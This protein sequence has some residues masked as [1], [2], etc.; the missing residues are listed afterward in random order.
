MMLFV[1]KMC[2]MG[3]PVFRADNPV[4]LTN[5]LGRDKKVTLWLGQRKILCIK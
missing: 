5:D 1:Q 3:K 4:C 2:D